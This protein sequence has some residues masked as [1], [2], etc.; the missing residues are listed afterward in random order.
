MIRLTESIHKNE[1]AERLVYTTRSKRID[2]EEPS[3][4]EAVTYP[5]SVLLDPAVQRAAQVL[6]HPARDVLGARAP[7]GVWRALH[8]HHRAKLEKGHHA[9]PVDSIAEQLVRH[10]REAPLLGAHRCRAQ[11]LGHLRQVRSVQVF[12][13]VTGLAQSPVQSGAARALLLALLLV[14]QTARA[15][16]MELPRVAVFRQLVVQIL[17]HDAPV[18]VKISVRHVRSKKRLSVGCS[19]NSLHSE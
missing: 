11:A 13:F 14:V 10:S 1:R 6:G 7:L 4:S 9:T 3:R 19:Y 17:F 8:A 12:Q 18:I 15:T 5:S 2:S 16:P